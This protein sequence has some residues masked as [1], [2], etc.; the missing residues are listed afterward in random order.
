[1]LCAK[2]CFEVQ[3]I[4]K[5]IWPSVY[6]KKIPADKNLASAAYFFIQKTSP[7]KIYTNIKNV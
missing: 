3:G 2:L 6:I 5:N 4:P 1:M 7:I